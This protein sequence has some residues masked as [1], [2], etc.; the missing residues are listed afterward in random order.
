VVGS[1]LA[2]VGSR[3]SAHQRAASVAYGKMPNRLSS[4]PG[5]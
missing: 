5:P 2:L 1:E 4:A 3:T